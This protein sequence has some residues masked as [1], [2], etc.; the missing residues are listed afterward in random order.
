MAAYDN[1]YS[2]LVAWLKVILP[3]AALAILSTVFLVSR[4]YDPEA[5]IPYSKAAI[6]ELLREQR[7]SAPR[8]AGMTDDGAAISIA[9]ASAQPD[10][11]D[12]ARLTTES[13]SARVETPGGGRLD[14]V[15]GRGSIDQARGLARM[16]GDVRLDSSTGYDIRAPAVTARLNSTRVETEGGVRAE[17]PPGR[18]TADRMIL[19]RDPA[20][21]QGDYVLDFAGNVRLIYQPPSV[22]E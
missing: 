15:A 17:G 18:I 1:L 16:E 11:G 21:P 14:I 13:L 6:D 4:R 8:Y 10:P 7:I 12:A 2:R 5:S 22:K 9:A 20:D 19:T 3:L